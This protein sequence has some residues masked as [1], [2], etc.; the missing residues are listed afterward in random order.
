MLKKYIPAPVLRKYRQIKMEQFLKDKKNWKRILNFRGVRLYGGP[1]NKVESYINNVGD[2]YDNNN[3][4]LIKEIVRPGQTCFDIGANI[5]V[6]TLFL[7]KITGNPGNIHSFEPVD[8]I[9]TKLSSNLRLNNFTK[10]HINSFAL[11]AQ[12]EKQEMYAVKT[13]T[14]RG[15]TST[16]VKNE[17]VINMGEDKFDR[18]PVEIRSMDDYVKENNITQLDFIKIDVEGFEWDV[19]K[20]GSDTIKNLRPKMII[21]YDPLRHTSTDGTN[22]FLSF[23]MQHNYEVFE[24]L[25]FGDDVVLMPYDFKK[26]PLHRNLFCLPK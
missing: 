24:F 15:G 6:Y 16:F 9:R 19:L 26:E 14:Y 25:A 12:S 7:A 23:F 11:G 20:G 2:L 21:E 22:D 1:D 4:S 5:G 13:G 10:V 18:I 3:F 17:N 8:H